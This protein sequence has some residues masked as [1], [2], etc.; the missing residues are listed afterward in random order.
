MAI[1]ALR[2]DDERFSTLPD[3]PYAPNYIDDLKGYE[4]LRMHYVDE[5]PKDAKITFL[6]LHGMPT[7]SYLYRKMLPIFVAARCRVVAL[8]M[9]GFGRSD[10]PILDST[11]SYYFHRNSLLAFVEKLD[12]KNICLTCQDWG[13]LLGL[14]LPKEAPDRYT[15]LIAMNTT[16]PMGEDPGPGFIAWRAYNKANPDLDIAA[17]MGRVVPGMSED[18]VAAYLAPFPDQRYKAGIRRFPQMVMVEGGESEGI[19]T[20]FAA[21]EFWSNRWEGDSFM[22]VGMQD[23]VLGA[24]HMVKLKEIVR[25]TPD[26]LELETV[27]HFVQETGEEVAKAALQHFG[28]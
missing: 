18:E 20:A 24:S 12:L 15:R 1:E 7:W 11:Y 28:I 4:G 6:C 19:D 14:T 22:A 9:F 16:L 21:A 26:L 2:T 25:G 17:L 13:G 3:W 5:G 27:G 8:D 23:P 10:K